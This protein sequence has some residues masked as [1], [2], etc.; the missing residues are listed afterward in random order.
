[1][2]GR[3][4]VIEL[5][6]RQHREIRELFDEVA[7]AKGAARTDAYHR[8]VRLLAVHET[9]EEQVVHPAA[10]EGEGG[11]AVVDARV[12]EERRAKEL[13][14]SM[15]KIGPDAEGFDTLLAQLRDD[16]LSHAAHEEREEFPRLRAHYDQD[17]LLALA[18]AVRAA[19]RSPPRARTRVSS[20]PPRTSSSARR[21]PCSTAPAT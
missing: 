17:R 14:V 13:L 7:A 19:K 10:R 11:D 21:W 18:G 15:D 4:D 12:A 3:E 8:L 16:T 2:T 20:R 6:V 9:A 5:L 1:M